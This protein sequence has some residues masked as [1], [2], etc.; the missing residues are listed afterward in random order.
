M[1]IEERASTHIYHQKRMFSKDELSSLE[2]RCVHEEPAYC[3]A[4]CP[5]K[6]DARAMVSAVAAGDFSGAMTLYKKAAVLP[7]ILASGCEAPCREKCR[8]GQVGESIDIPAIERAAARF[9]G[10]SVGRRFFQYKK[11]KTAVIFGGGLFAA[12]YMAEIA[13]KAYPLTVYSQFDSPVDFLADAAPFTDEE[14]ISG[15]AGTL[16]DAG[17]CFIKTAKLTPEFIKAESSGFDLIC[18]SPAL[19]SQLGEE[20]DSAVMLGRESDIISAPPENGVLSAAFAARKAA[21][22]ADRLAQGLSSDSTRGAEGAVDTKLYT[23]MTGVKGSPSVAA[24]GGL[25]SREEAAQ[26]AKR[27]IQCRCDECIKGCAYLRH[28][29]KYPKKLT[30]EI[31]NNV[32]IIMGDHMMNKPINACSLC[33]QCSVTCPNGYDMGEICRQA[34]QNMVSTDKM[35]LAPHEFALND[36]EFSNGEAFLCRSQPGFDKCRYMFFPGCQA[37]AIAPDT[38]EAAYRDLAERLEGGVGLLLGC[39]GA[40]ADWAGRESMYQETVKM[41]DSCLHGMGSPTVIAGCPTCKKTLAGHSGINVIGIWDALEDIGL[42]AGA[43]GLNTKAVMH[44]SCGARGDQ[45]TQ[46]A[47][48]RL[49]EKLG[50]RI[51]E[52]EYSGDRAPCCGYGGLVMYANPEVAHEMAGS[53]LETSGA[54]YLSYCMACR[55]RLAREGR[56]SRHILELVYGGGAGVPP[57]IS[58]KRYNRLSLKKRLLEDIWGEK[59]PE[60]NCGF[61][62]DFTPEALAAM[63]DRMILKSDVIHALNH[64]RESGELIFDEDS[65]LFITRLRDG[66]VTF[67]VKYTE[68]SDGYVVHSAYSHRMNVVT[69]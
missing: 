19:F 65:G 8:M 17:I 64:M 23:N 11:K 52:G 6:L 3:S 21:L 1:A 36:M 24:A 63:D 38:V 31:Y 46:K 53:C 69:R 47:V 34:R 56:E 15:D 50:C 12:F 20:L 29:N 30:R 62:V 45:A 48:R 39:C 43:G 5:L 25:Y 16:A 55:D 41:L 60:D 51:V 13:R 37:A 14:G 10:D 44:D 32:S 28:Y 27:C 33:S 61:T 54:P 42:P 68:K 67:W 66:N 35:T 2:N 49:A 7:H 22:T 59:M 4:A 57:D 18:V 26:E 9:G 40:I 58:E